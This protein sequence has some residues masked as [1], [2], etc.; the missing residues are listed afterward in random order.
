MSTSQLDRAGD[1]RE[2]AIGD[3]DGTGVMHGIQN[4]LHSGGASFISHSGLSGHSEEVII[5]KLDT[6]LAKNYQGTAVSLL[7]ID[8]EGFEAKVINGAQILLKSGNIEIVIME[9]S[10][11]FGEVSYLTKVSELIGDRYHWL[12]LE[13]KG[14]FKRSPRLREISLE[15]SLIHGQQWNLVLVRKDIFDSYL[16]GAHSGFL[17]CLK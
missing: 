13:E 4:E 12:I 3:S 6:A 16:N 10:P 14:K 1:V 11:N 2:Y 15:D 7:K 9:V 17:K 8:T 5:R